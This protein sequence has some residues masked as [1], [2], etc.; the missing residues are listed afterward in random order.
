M[1]FFINKHSNFPELIMELIKD[2][3]S[4]YEDFFE[5]IQTADIRFKMTD[6]DTGMIKV[7][8]RPAFCTSFDESNEYGIGYKF[9]DEDVDRAGTYIGQFIISF[10]DSEDRLIVPIREEL[11]IYVVD[12]TIKV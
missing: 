4:D 7:P 3:H 5:K 2:N 11:K 1:D 8:Y 9:K 6:A 10:I 12:G